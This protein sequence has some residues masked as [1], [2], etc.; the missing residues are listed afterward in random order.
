MI[1]SKNSSRIHWTLATAITS[2][3]LSGIA[4]SEETAPQSPETAPEAAR[5][6][7]DQV[8]KSE[9][10][11]EMAVKKTEIQRLQEDQAK[12]EQDAES[13]KRTIDS[14]SGLITESNDHL[15]KLTRDSRQLE[16]DL[17]VAQARISAEQLKT[18]GLRALAD[19]QGKTL[20]ALISRSAEAAARSHLRSVELELLQDG[21]PVPT[22]THQD[23]QSDIA[24]ARKALVF[25]QAKAD[26]E[27]R[28]AHEAMKAATAKMA[29]AEAKAGM[30]QRLA[31]N[32]LTL[33]P[34]AV[35]SKPKAK[36]TEQPREKPAPV[37][38]GPKPAAA[39]AP[40]GKSTFR[41]GATA[42]KKGAGQANTAR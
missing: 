26:S 9:Q 8:Q 36:S 6:L 23:P 28:L 2:L 13:L 37:A 12:T 10:D 40:T 18:A 17:A 39:P 30:A 3:L 15:G 38:A 22:E 14:T 16:H 33:E 35:P 1:R 32:D 31:D 29:L 7:L 19:A 4:W 24:K 21:K 11:R 34:T 27:E 20:S 25:A 5:T 41:T 42:T